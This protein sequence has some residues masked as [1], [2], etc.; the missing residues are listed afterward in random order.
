MR[1]TLPASR[2]VPF[3]WSG[4]S[5]LAFTKLFRRNALSAKL[6]LVVVLQSLTNGM[7]DLWQVLHHVAPCLALPSRAPPGSS[8]TRIRVY[9]QT[10][11]RGV[12]AAGG[13]QV[14]TWL[15]PNMARY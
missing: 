12:C 15:I 10:H 14:L 2:R 13:T 5:P 7:G 1:E 8:L 11:V 4:S 3:K 9:L 6:N